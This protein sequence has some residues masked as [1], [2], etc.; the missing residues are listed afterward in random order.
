MECRQSGTFW[1]LN[2]LLLCLSLA[3]GMC[4][5]KRN[6]F[7]LVAILLCQLLNLPAFASVVLCVK[8]CFAWVIVIT[9]TFHSCSFTESVSIKA[10]ATVDTF[11]PCTMVLLFP[12]SSMEFL[13]CKSAHGVCTRTLRMDCV[14]ELHLH[15]QRHRC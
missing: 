8:Q 3:N 11:S 15:L 7:T 13:Y 1:G 4:C 9:S 14:K 12:S 10:S 2:A 5:E 6:N